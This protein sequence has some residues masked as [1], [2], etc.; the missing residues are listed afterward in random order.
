MS[1]NYFLRFPD[2]ERCVTCGHADDQADLM[3]GHS[4]GGWV[5]AW[6]GYHSGDDDRT[7]GRQL[8][9]PGEWFTWL[10]AQCDAGGVIV[11]GDDKAISLGDFIVFVIRKRLP[12]NGRAPMIHSDT[13]PYAQPG[14]HVEGDDVGFHEFC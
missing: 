7:G 10:T 2:A 12:F 9:T 4:G 3:I 6:R 13:R 14:V 1:H 11:N 8:T 5:F